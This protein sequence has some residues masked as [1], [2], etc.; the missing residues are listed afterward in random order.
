MA[1][2]A[3]TFGVGGF[4][5]A[6]AAAMTALVAA[7]A[8]V[9][10][11]S[12]RVDAAPS[13]PLV[14]PVPTDARRDPEPS[15]A[16]L[17]LAERTLLAAECADSCGVPS[18]P[19]LR[20]EL[21]Q[22]DL[23]GH[24]RRPDDGELRFEFR[25]PRGTRDAVAAVRDGV[26]TLAVRHGTVGVAPEFVEWR[27]PTYRADEWLFHSD[28]AWARVTETPAKSLSFALSPATR[29]RVVA[30]ESGAP[31]DGARCDWSVASCRPD[32][33][34]TLRGDLPDSPE[35]AG[36]RCE[37]R[38]GDA[39]LVQG[40]APGLWREKV[41]LRVSA[42]GRFA[43]DLVLDLL[44][45]G[46]REV[47]LWPTTKVE[48]RTEA[49]PELADVVAAVRLVADVPTLHWSRWVK[50][51]PSGAA[52]EAPSCALRL[53]LQWDGPERSID[54]ACVRGDT[55]A[56]QPR[57]IELE[58]AQLEWQDA[59]A[60]RCGGCP[61]GCGI[62]LAPRALASCR[63]ELRDDGTVVPL[64]GFER[65]EWWVGGRWVDDWWPL[66]ELDPQLAAAEAANDVKRLGGAAASASRD[67]NALRLDFARTGRVRVTLPSLDGF[68]PLEPV[69]FDVVA[70]DDRELVVPLRREGR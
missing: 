29:V 44:G 70:G 8:G 19:V 47:R 39:F 3:A 36:L 64:D 54:P 57:F 52:T 20:V 68:W 37:R 16:E 41:A 63:I 30:A 14:P 6:T 61:G 34:L 43:R 55:A 56:L 50:L 10:G 62:P 12:G 5:F 40:G 2:G 27:T 24:R 35:P 58:G 60:F 9:V 49:P 66:D 45:G 21:E 42:P 25:T 38:C 59:H 51:G 28:D 32:P 18:E 46:D 48:I 22:I 15:A 26:A 1:G 4:A 69:E 67:R 23:H 65:A 33:A 53:L 17:P 11:M 7:A 13:R 31:L